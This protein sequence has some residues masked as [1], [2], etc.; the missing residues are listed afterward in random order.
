MYKELG[1]VAG[2]YEVLSIMIVNKTGTNY[3]GNSID[4]NKNLSPDGSKLVIPKNA[5]VEIKYP[6]TDIKGQVK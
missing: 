5:I 2:V 4:I 3:S 6:D 1:K